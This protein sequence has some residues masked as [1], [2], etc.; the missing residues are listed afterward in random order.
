MSDRACR[1]VLVEDEISDITFMR[2]AFERGAFDHEVVDVLNGLEFFEYLSEASVS[3]ELPDLVLLDLSLPGTSGLD[4]LQEL[5][6]GDTCPHVVVIVLTSSSYKQ[7]V[8]AAYA[9]G[10]NAFVTKPARLK[11]LDRFVELIEGFWL[12]LAHLPGR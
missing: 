2:K 3:D 6:R 5:R 11:E 10:A 1:I 8:D 12:S 4:I 9:A 7:E